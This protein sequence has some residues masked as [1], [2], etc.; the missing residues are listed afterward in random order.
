MAEHRGQADEREAD[1]DHV[2]DQGHADLSPRGDADADDRDNQHD[3]ADAG[4]DGDVRPGA[5]GI[6]AEDGQ[7]RRA[8]H[9]DAAD[10]RDDIGGYHQPAG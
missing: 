8:E 10:G 4:A 1:Q 5:G 7:N 3:Q 9:F 2:L 6:G